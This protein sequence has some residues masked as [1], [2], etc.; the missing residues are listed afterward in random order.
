MK[1]R[2]RI[3]VVLVD[4]H[5]LF[6]EGLKDLLLNQGDFDVVGEGSDG[7]NAL[8][9][10]AKKKTDVLIIDMCMPNMGGLSAIKRLRELHPSLRIVVVSMYEDDDHKQEAFQAGAD[11]Y[12]SKMDGADD[13]IQTIRRLMSGKKVIDESLLRL[14]KREWTQPSVALTA[15]EHKILEE[16][17]LGLPNKEM[18]ARLGMSERTVKN[19]LTSVFNKMGVKSRVEAVRKGIEKKWLTISL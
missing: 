9:I 19:H 10:V 17:S 3:K 16:L 14:P 1:E 18:G 5:V 15:T 7:M 8:G 2:E 11:A 12:H 6:R 13:V 4:D